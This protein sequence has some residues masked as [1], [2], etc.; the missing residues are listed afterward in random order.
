MFFS[1]GGPGGPGGGGMPFG[2]M[3]GM[4]GMGGA[5]HGGDDDEPAKEVNTTAYYEL[6]GV[7][8]ECTQTELKKA[9]MALARKEH[10]DKGGDPERFKQITKAYETL[11]D[12]EK[13]AAY[14]RFGEDAETGGGGPQSAEDIF[15]MMFGGG[16][17]APAGPRKTDDTLHKLTVSLEDCY[18]GK[19]L[20]VPVARSIYTKDP[21]GNIRDSAGNRLSKKVERQVVEVTIERGMKNGQRVTFAGM[22]DQIPGMLPGDVVIVVEQKQH[23]VFQRKGSDLII[24]REITLLESLTGVKLVVEHLDGHKVLVSSAPGDVIAPDSVKQVPDEGMPVYGHPHVRGVLFVQFE[25]K[26]PEKLELTDAMRK[27]LGGILPAPAVA[28]PKAEAGVLERVLEEPDMEQ[29]RARERLAKDAYDSDEEGG[30]G[31]G[32]QRVQCAHQ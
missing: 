32:A 25:V 16:R 4:G 10:P 23:E 28:P 19:T 21:T 22:G 26:F 11:A 7:A 30:H 18:G 1:F 27:V 24:K 13:R 17:R 5:G 14:D 20:K 2:G 15:S 8:K 31:G 3:G 29:R 12:P 6:L 9:Y